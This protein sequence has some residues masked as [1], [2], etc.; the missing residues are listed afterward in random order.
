MNTKLFVGGIA[1]A[2]TEDALKAAFAQAGAVVSAQILLDR[3]TGRSRGFGFVEMSS[4]E[5]AQ[6]AIEM[7]NGKDLDGRTLVVNEARPLADR[8]PRSGGGGGRFDRRGGGGG[9]GYRPQ[10]RGDRGG[11]RD[12]RGGGGGYQDE[13]GGRDW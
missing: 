3:V 7:W 11:R 4:A 5:D 6:K 10:G 13:T 9:G 1:W 8:P 2:T 12:R